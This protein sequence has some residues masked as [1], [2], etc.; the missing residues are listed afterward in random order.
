MPRNPAPPAQGG[1]GGERGE[2]LGRAGAGDGG[3]LALLDLVIQLH[4]KHDGPRQVV[5][6]F[7]ERLP[8]IAAGIFGDLLTVRFAG[9]RLLGEPVGNGS[10]S[11]V[12]PCGS[13]EVTL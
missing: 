9:F 3:G 7:G 11:E 4:V 13:K 10:S 1:R 8:K 6:S 2:S 12:V 5:N